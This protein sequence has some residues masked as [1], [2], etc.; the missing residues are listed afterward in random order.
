MGVSDAHLG[1]NIRKE[2]A[3]WKNVTEGKGK[4]LVSP[5]DDNYVLPAACPT[6]G[7]VSVPKKKKGSEFLN[8]RHR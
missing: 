7:I 1:E 6:R 2:W 4:V 5:M 3:T 8:L